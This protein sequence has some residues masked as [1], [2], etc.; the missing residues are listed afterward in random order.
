MKQ[1]NKAATFT[2]IYSFHVEIHDEACVAIST[3]FF[4]YVVG[5]LGLRFSLYKCEW[6]TVLEKIYFIVTARGY[7]LSEHPYDIA[8]PSMFSELSRRIP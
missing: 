3:P 2:L 8:V 5:G 1:R 4:N 6:V 7:P